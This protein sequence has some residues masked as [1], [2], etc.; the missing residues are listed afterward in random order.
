MCLSLVWFLSESSCLL[1]YNFYMCAYMFVH[2]YAHMSCTYGF[3]QRPEEV[4]DLLE[5]ELQVFVSHL[6]WPLEADALSHSNPLHAF[7]TDGQRDKRYCFILT[8][9]VYGYPR[10]VLKDSFMAGKC[11]GRVRRAK[12]ELNLSLC[13][14]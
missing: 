1:K 9:Y 11:W 4:M 13:S 2:E 5:L 7:L 6:M 10:E 3:L 12:C 8:S 14:P